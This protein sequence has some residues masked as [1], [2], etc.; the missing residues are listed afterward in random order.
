MLGNLL[1]YRTHADSF[2]DAA[3]GGRQQHHIILIRFFDDGGCNMIRANQFY[4]YIP[5]NFYF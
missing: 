2:A 3:P 5:R 4:F 1:G